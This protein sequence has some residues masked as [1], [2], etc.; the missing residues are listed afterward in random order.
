MSEPTWENI[1]PIPLSTNPAKPDVW[2]GQNND[3]VSELTARTVALRQALDMA[4]VAWEIVGTDLIVTRENGETITL[5]MV[6]AAAINSAVDD[7][8]TA[9]PPAGV[10][11]TQLA[12]LI[13]ADGPAKTA[14]TAQ[15]EAPFGHLV[16]GADLDDVLDNLPA[17][18][19]GD[20]IRK[21]TVYPGNYTR[22]APIRVPSGVDL[23]IYGCKFTLAD[24][25]NCDVITNRDWAAG[26]TNI[27]IFGGHLDGNQPGQTNVVGDGP[28][29]SG[30]SMC[31]TR[32]WV[33][34]DVFTERT[35][36]HGI[37]PCVR[38]AAA[39]SHGDDCSD[40]LIEN[41]RVT[42]FGDDGITPHWARRGVIRGCWAY[43]GTGTYTQNSNGFEMD[44]GCQDI[45]VADCIAYGNPGSGF[46]IQSHAG[47]SG[48]ARWQMVNCSSYNNGDHGFRLS[49]QNASNVLRNAQLVGCTSRDNNSDGL[50]VE[51][52]QDCTITAFQ[53]INDG[54]CG[55]RLMGSI[56]KRILVDGFSVY[57]PDA[58]TG[59]QLA[60]AHQT[61]GCSFS[62]GVIEA[63]PGEGIFCQ[64]SDIAF[65]D[66]EVIGCGAVGP[67]PS[68]TVLGSAARV[69]LD[70]VRIR[71]SL[72]H[73]FNFGGT[74]G[75]IKMRNCSATAPAAAAKQGVVI[76]GTGA[77]VGYIIESGL[78][79]GW[80]VGIR[81][82]A[83]NIGGLEILDNDLTGNTTAFNGSGGS[84]PTTRRNNVGYV[85][86]NKGMGTVAADA[87][88]VT[89]SHGLA[90]APSTV[91]IT[92][93]SLEAVAVTARTASTF[94][95]T[96]TANASALD[97]DWEAKI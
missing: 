29:Q 77:G 82:A 91:N 87:A 33:I 7:Y 69:L 21:V 72:H 30:I 79:N 60:E 75:Q 3:N 13:E 78:F 6:Q 80:S 48:G 83:A 95:V 52:F 81:H 38:D 14:L 10:T 11:S 49:N 59:L 51:N 22:S 94:T 26:N 18:T 96:R 54:V 8:L 15:I 39:N 62:N 90:A 86:E 41:C 40:F 25:S 74:G 88:T 85:T 89:V 35:V 23:S 61:E 64:Q 24:G 31:N 37:D 20:P 66:I 63:T 56:T 70:G 55:I 73:G 76:G 93:R 53:S 27:R 43:D 17:W 9:N 2:G 32:H 34:R 50:R 28:G 92:P 36:L 57:A 68:V 47:R 5:P 4:G 65:R 1:D 46:V 42:T 44:D 19:S 71:D 84:T 58:G 16:L 67:K 45:L 12:D 97:F